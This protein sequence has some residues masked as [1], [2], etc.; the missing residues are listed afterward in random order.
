VTS[1][2][3]SGQ[4][5]IKVPRED[6]R[7]LCWPSDHSVKQLL[8]LNH[9]GLENPS[10]PRD[11]LNLRLLAREQAVS[12]ALLHTRAYTDHDLEADSQT[13]LILSGHQPELFHP[14]VWFKNFFL[15][16]LSRSSPSQG[17][18]VTIDHDLAKAD[19]LRVPDYSESSHGMLGTY[20]QSSVSLP[21]RLDFQS[22]S[23]WHLTRCENSLV[24]GWNDVAIS[25]SKSL[26]KC[27]IRNSVLQTRIE[28]LRDCLRSCE[29][30]GDAFSRFRHRIEWEHG[31]KN[32]EVPLGALCEGTAFG[33]FV[34][35]CAVQASS[36]WSVYNESRNQYRDKYGIKNQ[37]QPVLELQRHG[38]SLE[39]PFWIYSSS[40]ALQDRKR[41]WFLGASDDHRTMLL[42]DASTNEQCS[43]KIS[44]PIVL[45]EFDSAWKGIV[46]DGICVRPR[47]LMTT[48]YLRFLV[49]D[50]FVH[51]IGGGAYDELTDR[52]MEKWLGL[53]APAYLISSASLHLPFPQRSDGRKT[54]RTWGHLQQQLQWM[55][56][57]PE[58]FLDESLPGHGEIFYQHRQ[59]L[60]T[61]P[62]RGAKRQ[63]HQDMTAMKAR[64][65]SMIEPKKREL[66]AQC[67]AWENSSQQDRIRKSREYSFVLFPEHDVVSRLKRLA[68]EARLSLV[69]TPHPK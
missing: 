36:L 35:R 24:D 14:G 65:V 50:L 39:L 43:L 38:D 37:A 23:P 21:V 19:T 40:D 6:N 26:A 44:L 48:T 62:P 18:N 20:E 61:M 28:L 15:A 3:S 25:I 10:V 46:A 54:N 5:S 68:I 2:A 49:A 7:Y 1:K 69:D 30:I 11:L 16:E 12:Q 47:A 53:P 51:G 31:V 67:Q 52:I 58:R 41:M 9:K 17:L 45:D 56:S 57:V 33:R 34:L 63:W 29:N 59:L 4:R 42:G 66:M 13:R 22:R 64:I 32:L 60:A 27:G 8:E 55:R